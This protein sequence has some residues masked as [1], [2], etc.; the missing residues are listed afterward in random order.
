MAKHKLGL[1][2]DARM[3]VVEDAPSG[4]RAGKNA[5]C[6]VLGL[7]TTH[8]VDQVVEAGADWVIQDLKSLRV[9]D[10]R[11]G[12]TTVEICKSLAKS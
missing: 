9:V 12:V 8:R 11:N 1:A 2:E 3:L 4:I 6:R 7:A 5:G 10:Q